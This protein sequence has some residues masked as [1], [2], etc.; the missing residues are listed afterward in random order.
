MR[1]RSADTFPLPAATDGFIK[2]GHY[3]YA[4]NSV[5]Y[6]VRQ[7][8]GLVQR[9]GTVGRFRQSRYGVETTLAMAT[10]PND[11]I[12]SDMVHFAANRSVWELTLR[13]G[14]GAFETVARGVFT[15]ILALNQDYRF[16]MAVTDDAVT[17]TVPGA[18][19]TKKVSTAGTRGDRA[20]W[21][22]YF[23]TKGRPAGVV[24][25]FDSVWAAEE[26]QP[27]LPVTQP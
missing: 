9:M 3:T 25:D 11:Q 24:F 20:F 21:E 5:V 4:G 12:V 13:R 22:E 10:T 2:D 16:E 23:D 18:E 27:M 15:P 1:G 7:L 26:G 14:N 8:R 6:A 17:V 19:V